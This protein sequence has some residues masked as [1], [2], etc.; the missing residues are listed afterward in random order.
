[1]KFGFSF[2]AK[3]SKNLSFVRFSNM[4]TDIINLTPHDITVRLEDGTEKTFP[5]S[6]ETARVEVNN[7]SRG[8]LDGIEVVAQE[9]GEIQGLPEPQ[10]GVYYLVS[11]V[12]RQAAVEQGRS[13]CLSPDTSPAG[14]IRNEKGMIV[15]VRRFVC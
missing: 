4:K 3:S 13:D 14:A 11:L 9:Y 12:V 7:K 2:L 6:G 10:D 8:N 1:M 5:A 15:A